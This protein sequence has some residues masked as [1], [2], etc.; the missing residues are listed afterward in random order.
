LQALKHCINPK[1][2]AALVAVGG[3]V[4]VFAPQAFAAALPLLVLAICPLSMVLMMGMMTRGSGAGSSSCSDESTAGDGADVQALQ[5]R[6]A[7]LESE[8]GRSSDLDGAA[9]P[10]VPRRTV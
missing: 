3:G 5:A 8:L 4:Y 6:V 9:A 1:V 2:I 7:E 10:R